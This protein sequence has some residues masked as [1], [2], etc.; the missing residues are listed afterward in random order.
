[1]KFVGSRLRR[2]FIFPYKYLRPHANQIREPTFKWFSFFIFSPPGECKSSLASV[3]L[4]LLA[5][6]ASVKI[7]LFPPL[8]AYISV[9]DFAIR[10]VLTVAN[11]EFESWVVGNIMKI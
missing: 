2:S 10:N 4:D 8:E 6:L 1:M 9:P 5:R 7:I 3:K 11:F